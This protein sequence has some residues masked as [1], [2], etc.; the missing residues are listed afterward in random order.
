MLKSVEVLMMEL[1]APSGS[2]TK[3]SELCKKQPDFVKNTMI[4]GEKGR[5]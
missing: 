1:T 3:Y 4:S 2:L 5:V